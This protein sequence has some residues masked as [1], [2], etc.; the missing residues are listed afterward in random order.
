MATTRVGLIGLG[1]V[2]S[3][4]ARLLLERRELIA[5]RAD[6]DLELAAAAD[7][8]PERA[9]E[10][11]LPAGVFTTDA[12]ALLA[13]PD[14]DVVVEL[15]GGL[16]PAREFLL[17]ALSRGRS[18]V[19]ANKHL[20]AESYRELAEAARAGGAALFFEAAVAGGIPILKSLREG[21]TA[22]RIT[23]VQGIV[24]GTC[25]YILSEMTARG[26]DFRTALAAAQAQGFAEADPALD[27]EGHDSAHKLLLLATLAF[28]RVFSLRDVHVEG[29]SRVTPEDI[30]YA[31]EM[32]FVVKLL[33]AGRRTDGGFELRVYPT[34]LEQ[35]HPLAAV[36]GVFNAVLVEG[37]AVGRLMFYGR[38]AGQ[39]PTASAVLADI[40][41]A[42]RWRELPAGS[43]ARP[44]GSIEDGRVLP[45]AETR[46]RFF[47]RFN[48]IDQF[49]VLGKIATDLG[50]RQVSIQVVLQK[51]K[52]P[53][54]VVPV[55]M[56]T[57]PARE[58]DF[59]AAIAAIDQCDF[60]LEP[61]AFIRAGTE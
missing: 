18:A 45:M 51:E 2:G 6:V 59:R 56:L 5:A 31:G 49:G 46:S 30:H 47:C 8:R 29:I 60:V 40:I 16:S 58:A 41:D 57:H 33:A 9:E 13:R 35:S 61:T 42:A 11:G 15:V 24:N 32:G 14:L 55:V 50:R 4:V 28:D 10:L 25:N 53:D 20:L 48:V 38:G 54:G 1:T 44:A 52:R 37:D 27:V 43:R 19:T 34:L 22:N 21:L 36:G 39:M 12:A 17:A 3:G 23:A 26:T 7:L